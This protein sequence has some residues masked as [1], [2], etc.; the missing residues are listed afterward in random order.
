MLCRRLLRCFVGGVIVDNILSWFVQYGLI[1]LAI[2]GVGGIFQGL[3]FFW[4]V[5]SSNKKNKLAK[6]IYIQNKAIYIQ[7]SFNMATTHLG[8]QE[9]ASV[10]IVA[11]SEFYKIAKT[12]S[13]MRKSI[14]DNLC[15]HLRHT[16]KHGDYK[17]NLKPTEEVQSLL[18]ILFKPNNENKAQDL[19]EWLSKPKNK[20]ILIFSGL[21]ANLAEAHLQ[22]A[23]LQKANLQEANLQGA[24]LQGAD[25]QGADLQGADLQGADLQGAEIN[26]ATTVMPDNWKSVVKLYED[27]DGKKKPMVKII[28]GKE[29]N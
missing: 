22:G 4:Q 2:V 17:N 26:E 15:S 11:F 21:E 13:D 12:E 1:A 20:I 9:S 6:A 10:R 24:N 23:D 5:I 3:N 19:L 7:K 27:E 25:L 18:D 28:E 29:K 14:F 8:N 16:I